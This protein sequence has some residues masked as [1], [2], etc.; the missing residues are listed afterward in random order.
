MSNFDLND[1]LYNNPLFEDE[2][3]KAD[4]EI[5]DVFKDAVEDFAD[6]L[7][8]VKADVKEAAPLVVAGASLAI[9]EILK[10]I[11][12]I[13][14]KFSSVI[15]RTGNTG[16]KII[17]VADKLHGVLT[18]V[19][20]KGLRA[21][22]AKEGSALDKIVDGLYHVLIASL[23][24]ASGAGSVKAFKAGKIAM[25]SLE[26]AL[27][28]VKSNEVGRFLQDLI[29][30]GTIGEMKNEQLEFDDDFGTGGEE[31]ESLAAD[32]VMGRISY[33]D[34][35]EKASKASFSM[36]QLNNAISYV[37]DITGKSA[38]NYSIREDDDYDAD[39]EQ[40]D[41]NVGMGYD[42]EGRPLGEDQGWGRSDQFALVSSMHR[43]LGKPSK[44]PRL[45]D[46]IDAAESATDFYMDDFESYEDDKEGLVM[47]NA[48]SY[49]RQFFPKMFDAMK[50]FAEPLDEGMHTKDPRQI[51][52]ENELR[53][54]AMLYFLRKIRSGE[55]DVLPK[56]PLQAY[57]DML[58]QDQMDHD[59]ETL[60]RELGEGQ[61]G[62]SIAGYTGFG[63][64]LDSVKMGTGNKY[65]IV[66]FKVDD[67]VIIKNST[68]LGVGTVTGV[69][70]NKIDGEVANEMVYRVEFPDDDPNAEDTSFYYDSEL[71]FASKKEKMNERLNVARDALKKIHKELGSDKFS[72]MILNI[73]D[74]NFLDELEYVLGFEYRR[75]RGEM[76]EGL[77]IGGKKVKA[78]HTH[79]SNN[80]EDHT[81]E[82]EDGT[83]EPYLKHLQ[84]KEARDYRMTYPSY[85]VEEFNAI[86]DMA[87]NGILNLMSFAEQHKPEVVDKIKAVAEEVMNLIYDD[88]EEFD[89]QP[90]IS[91][92]EKKGKDYDGDGDIDSDDY[93]MARDKAIK[94]A[95]KSETKSA[96]KGH[97]FTKSGNLVKGRITKDARERGATISDP[98]DKRRSKI[99]PVTQVREE[100][101]DQRVF[102]GKDYK[103]TL[104][105]GRR[106]TMK[107]VHQATYKEN[108]SLS[109]ERAKAVASRI[110]KSITEETEEPTAGQIKSS[111]G[112]LASIA[113][114][115]AKVAKDMKGLAKEYKVAKEA[116]DDKKVKD[117]LATL[118]VL[119]A[120]KKQLEKDLDKA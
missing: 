120:H 75:Y 44:F 19:I 28:A 108:P 113:G 48:R 12:K 74:E 41:E 6:E 119:T 93:L 5:E 115:L 11:G 80:V 90:R 25:S 85:K 15:G 103:V 17:K 51:E 114:K 69:F 55:I 47:M 99:P 110:Y 18:G 86:G 10:I 8:N 109:K 53:D 112:S 1:Y 70:P 64:R 54:E 77:T 30:S 68:E 24:L 45:S 111:G 100:D 56:N 59:A 14:K 101:G 104:D 50:K 16:E 91:V 21:I 97:Y 29:G 65:V 57:M 61:R 84:M 42:D 39:F 22:G 60:R 117:L 83:E 62:D 82:Y 31:V 66:R 58:T 37:E 79:D 23:M 13:T 81:I 78:I 34:A 96:P 36:K 20:K 43:E 38:P 105:K 72:Q 2:D 27:T 35:R 94:K 107:G 33:K 88:M 3:K 40:D 118:K 95:M 4:K 106:Y 98:L 67:E 7:P 71:S 87:H 116:G 73:R 102:K 46:L 89:T 26:A 9:P 49:A 52:A 63:D 76:Q 92:K 32:V